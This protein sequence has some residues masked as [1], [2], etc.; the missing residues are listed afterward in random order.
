MILSSGPFI[1]S[2]CYQGSDRMTQMSTDWRDV[3]NE[4]AMGFLG[5]GSSACGKYE[6]LS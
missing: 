6:L 4:I 5:L 2:L 1:D 3:A